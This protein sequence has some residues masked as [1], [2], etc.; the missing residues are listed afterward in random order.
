VPVRDVSAAHQFVRQGG[1]AEAITGWSVT[2]RFDGNEM[3]VNGSYAPDVADGG[4]RYALWQK[5][6]RNG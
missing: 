3:L 4:H 6:E 2:G 1:Q 5:T